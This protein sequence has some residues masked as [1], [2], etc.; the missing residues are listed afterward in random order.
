MAL[1]GAADEERATDDGFTPGDTSAAAEDSAPVPTHWVLGGDLTVADGALRAGGST[2][3]LSVVDRDL[4]AIAC[5]APVSVESSLAATTPDPAAI[6]AWWSALAPATPDCATPPATLSLGI[7][8]LDA[9]LRARLGPAGLS[10]EAGS[11]LGAYLAL[12]GGTP[13]TFG[14]ARP[15]PASDTA[16]EALVPDGAWTI[17]PLYAVPLER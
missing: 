16:T 6:L 17:L 12:P 1:K 9:D 2:L 3:T 4:G 8:A 7:G 10:D 5:S 11:L 14:V 13:V 15:P